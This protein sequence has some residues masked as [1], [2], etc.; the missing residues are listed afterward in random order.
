MSS[1]QSAE[2]S[3]NI[4]LAPSWRHAAARTVMIVV[5]TALVF[6]LMYRHL[7]APTL[8]RLVRQNE[9]ARFAPTL[10]HGL[11]QLLGETSLVV[12]AAWVARRGLKVRL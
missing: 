2:G 4:R 5:A 9:I 12:F 7:G 6:G 8:R 11:L 3:V 10:G 1:S